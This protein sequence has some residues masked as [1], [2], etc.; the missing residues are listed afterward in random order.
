MKGIKCI[1]FDCMET[2]IDMFELPD[3]KDYA[4][5]AFENSGCKKYFK[6][7]NLFYKAYIDARSN[8]DGKLPEYR[9]YDFKQLYEYMFRKM[10]RDTSKRKEVVDLLLK[11]YWKNYRR[12]CYV[13]DKVKKTLEYLNIK[14]TL[15]VVSNFKIKGGI[16][17]LLR[18]TGIRSYFDFVINSAE[19]GW[20]K[21]HENIYLKAIKTSGFLSSEIIFVGDSFLNDYEGPRR[22][23][24]R[25]ILLD[26]KRCFDIDCK[27][28]YEFTELKR[29][30]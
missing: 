1:L 9:E 29:I 3:K 4:L 8:I 2:L 28:I 18:Y 12:R 13:A 24:I 22:V 5:W 26:K 27:K 11:S 10:E 23:G 25:S 17:D 14:Y 6:D 7:F 21:P 15:G 19:Q 30:L 20:R 16:E